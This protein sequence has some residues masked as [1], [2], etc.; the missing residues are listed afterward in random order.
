M[1]NTRGLFCSCESKSV[2]TG[3]LGCRKF[4]FLSSV[5]TWLFVELKL[6]M[7]EWMKRTTSLC[8]T[9]EFLFFDSLL[10]RLRP[11]HLHDLIFSCIHAALLLLLHLPVRPC[12]HRTDSLHLFLA[13]IVQDLWNHQIHCSSMELL[14]SLHES[15]IEKWEAFKKNLKYLFL[16]HLFGEVTMW[17][18]WSS[19]NVWI[20][21]SASVHPSL[22]FCLQTVQ[23]L[24]HGD[25]WN[26]CRLAMKKVPWNSAILVS[27]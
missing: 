6:E 20:Q 22:P 26:R 9:G 27:L 3:L 10:F 12:W 17:I 14:P 16:L 1:L 18:S 11:H 8:P 15:E 25:Q 19:N 13:T 24:Y 2:C 5:S 21:L 7:S 4:F 23:P